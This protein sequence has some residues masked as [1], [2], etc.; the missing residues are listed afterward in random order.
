LAG[1]QGRLLENSK[2]LILQKQASK[3]ANKEQTKS[4]MTTIQSIQDVLKTYQTAYGAEALQAQLTLFM[5]SP[6]PSVEASKPSS[7]SSSS[8]TPLSKLSNQELRDIWADLTG[9]KK[10]IKSSGKLAKK[11][12]LIAEIER[13]RSSPAEAE[14]SAKPSQDDK[15]EKKKRSGPSAWNAFI[16]SVAGKGKDETPEFA[17][18]KM[19]QA[20][21]KGNLR[22][23]FAS[24]LGKAVFEEFKSTYVPSSSAS[25]DESGDESVPVSSASSVASSASAEK[26]RGRPKMT[27]EE[28]AAK[29]EA[30][31]MAKTAEKAAAKAAKKVEKAAKKLAT[32]PTL[33]ESDDE[34]GSPSEYTEV[35]IGGENFLW[36]ESTGNLFNKTEDGSLTEVGTYDGIVFHFA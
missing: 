22:F 33:P 6:A 32:L 36:D 17:A 13:L 20:E 18:W 28:K 15:P 1:S 25:A 19:T 27:E 26:K 12:D 16:E 21:K 34:E 10:G 7:S 31:K 2:E 23:S 24:S 3:K 35:E 29:K 4:K 8:E 5:K 30:K 14:T 11:A 9:R